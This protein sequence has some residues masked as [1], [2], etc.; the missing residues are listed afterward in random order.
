MNW[1]LAVV[2]AVIGVALVGSGL[3]GNAQKLIT[4]AIGSGTPASSSTS[5]PASSSGSG[6]ST[7]TPPANPL[8]S[9]NSTLQNALN[10]IGQF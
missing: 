3:T 8:A 5:T 2:L 10:A 6:G 4:A 7:T 1:V 9:T